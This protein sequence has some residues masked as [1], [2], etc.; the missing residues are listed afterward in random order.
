MKKKQL[1]IVFILTVVLILTFVL[2]SCTTSFKQ[3]A[4][5]T[6]F[7]N[8]NVTS[9]GGLAVGVGNYVYFINGS[10]GQEGYNVWGKTVK[11]A[12]MRVELDADKNPISSTLT[13]IIPKNVHGTKK[14]GLVVLGDRIFFTSPSIN[15]NSKGEPLSGR[16]VLLSSKLDGTDVK[17]IKEFDSYDIE[18]KVTNNGFVLYLEE[19]TLY[20][21]NLSKRKP[22]AVEIDKEITSFKFMDYSTQKDSVF[23]KTIIYTKASENKADKFNTVWQYTAGGDKK[24]IFNGNPKGSYLGKEDIE[25]ING[26]TLALNQLIYVD[27]DTLRLVYNK[28]NAVD[29][30][31]NRSNGT[32]SYDFSTAYNFDYK[33][34]VRYSMVD[35]IANLRFI[36][37]PAEI[38]AG[39]F[40]LATKTSDKAPG[41]YY[42]QKR[43]AVDGFNRL[44]DLEEPGAQ[45]VVASSMTLLEVIEGQN[46][47][48]R[49]LD[50][51]KIYNKAILSIS[52]DGFT[53]LPL[54]ADLYLVFDKTA[55]TAW[56][57]IDNVHEGKYYYFNSDALK[58][59]Y[60][61]DAKK[62]VEKDKR[63]MV[64]YQVGKFSQADEIAM[65]KAIEGEE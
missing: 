1:G 16:M 40:V 64:A 26:Y 43:E 13:T 48:V 61:Y 22:K 18:Y 10:A 35:T 53:K 42:S 3:K 56:L 37:K 34:E 23:A 46:I 24:E 54:N 58:N 15:T 7:S 30:S 21:L 38:K 9:N 29:T 28:S 44:Y 41:L 5:Q 55:D 60:W 50:S 57:G 20:S 45:V 6:D 63:T 11:G 4:V 27:K 32:Y 59:T 36:G 8:L 51:N 52:S 31:S 25:D 19:G 49:Y 33:K 62:V 2:A 12:I 14:T 65:L 17:V 39:K 47:S